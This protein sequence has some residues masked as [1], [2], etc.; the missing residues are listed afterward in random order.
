[1]I[2][3]YVGSTEEQMLSV[4]VLEFSI[5]KHT[6]SPVQVFPLW[7]SDIKIPEPKDPRNRPRTPFSFQRFLIPA[8]AGY[9]GRAIYLDSDMQVFH[10]IEALWSLPFEGADLLAAYEPSSTGRRPQFSVMLMDCERLKWNIRDLVEQLDGGGL[11]YEDLVYRMQAARSIRAS[12]SPNWNSLER[13]EPGETSLI[14]YTDMDTQPWVS[15]AHPIAHIWFQDLFE[16][17]DQGSIAASLVE[18]HVRRGFIRPSVLW[19]IEKRHASST[20]LPRAALALDQDFVA[21]FRKLANAQSKSIGDRVKLR[22]HALFRRL[23]SRPQTRE[24]P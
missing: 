22:A 4:K 3:I 14:H 5:R 6:R 8:L 23:R 7:H 16:A 12:I 19:Q 11:S 21:P 9:V 1:M 15:T 18:E 24:V 13:Y 2:R 17:I 10:D 20:D